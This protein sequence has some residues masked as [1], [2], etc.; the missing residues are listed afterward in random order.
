ML[1]KI[2]TA[3]V[4]VLTETE[5]KLILQSRNIPTNTFRVVDNVEDAASAATDL[6][7]PV[8]I[9]IV[10]RKITHKSDA[11]GVV[12]DLRDHERLT[13]AYRSLMEKFQPIDPDVK[14]V[15]QQMVPEGVEIIIGANRDAQFGPVI[16]LGIGGIFTELLEDVSFAMLPVTDH[17]CW[18][19]IQSLRGY[20]LLKGFRGSE[21][22]AL[23]AIV[24]L[25][26]KVSDLVYA[27][28]KILEMDLNP[29]IVDR[30]H[31]TVVDARIVVSSPQS[32]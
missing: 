24:S 6:G 30:N 15:V 31:A 4:K 2:K 22:V 18:R 17:D 29:V 32:G 1:G 3:P 13:N 23:D 20:P 28:E 21:K 16:L 19:M 8:V 11:G 10:S 25:M 26:M 5:S 14:V 12:L 7:Y 9:K 27:D